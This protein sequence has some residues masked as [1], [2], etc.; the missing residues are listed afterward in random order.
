[1]LSALLL[2]SGNWPIIASVLYVSVPTPVCV[3]NRLTDAVGALEASEEKRVRS[4]KLWKEKCNEYR[5]R[6]AELQD[7]VEELKVCGAP[8]LPFVLLL[9]RHLR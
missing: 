4:E 5:E 7:T 1:M 8:P 3:V 2:F 9:T 6:A